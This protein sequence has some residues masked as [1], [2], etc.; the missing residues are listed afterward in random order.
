[1]TKEAESVCILGAGAMGAFYASKLYDL[2][3]QCVCLLAAGERFERLEKGG[4]IVNGAH[5]PVAVA[6]PDDRR[7]P[8]SLVIV[9][10]KHHH[11]PDAVGDLKNR[12]GERTVI[13]SVM[14]GIDSEETIGAEYGMERMLYA[15]AVGIDALREDNRL[16]YTHQG[17]LFFGEAR[18]T[19]PSDR[20][21]RIQRLFDR[22]G[23]AYE[24]P[25]DM[26]RILWWKFMINVG[27][28]QCSA[29]MQAPFGVFQNSRDAW[30]VMDA[31]MAEVMA[32][33]NHMDIQLSGQDIEDWHRVLA[34][35]APQGKTSML[36][37]IQAGRRTEV[38][39]LAGK[40]VAL[41]AQYGIPTPVNQALLRIIRVLESRSA[42]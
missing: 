35:I 6:A 11:L 12:V 29:V 27:V 19:E 13:M 37:D 33:A 25:P 16:T 26:M 15:V 32:I 34:G 21:G 41:G 8:S 5:Y 39:M 36:Q 18:N 31:T 1:V 2:D 40:V 22:A 10:L 42:K 14:N 38:E 23:I 24:T 20:V 9:A 7:P 4:L 28:N 3:P 17:K 30:D